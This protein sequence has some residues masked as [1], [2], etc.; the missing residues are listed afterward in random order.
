MEPTSLVDDLLWTIL[1]YVKG[2]NTNVIDAIDDMMNTHQSVRNAM[3]VIQADYKAGKTV[4]SVWV[5]Y[6]KVQGSGAA[7]PKGATGSDDV[8]G[9]ACP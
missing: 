4:C 7:L 8:Q 2:P 9:E 3:D 6:F 1:L 5:E